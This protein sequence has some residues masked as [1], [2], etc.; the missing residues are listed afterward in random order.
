MLDWIGAGIFGILFLGTA[1]KFVTSVRLVQQ[2]R[3]EV[4]E[5]LGRY[6]KT[7]N[8]GFHVLVPFVDKVAFRHDLREE[9][10][11]VPP[12][13][14]F[15]SDNVRV[16]V[17]GVI[18]LQVVN[19]E[20]A[21][22][23]ITNYRWAAM[24][25]AQTTTRAVIG[26][27]ELDRTFEDRDAINARVVSV[28]N[29]AARGWG[30]EVKRYEVKN[31]VP[32]NTVKDAME[33]QMAAERDRRA[34]LARAEGEKMSRINNAD[35][36][37]QDLINR[38]EGEKQKRINEAEGRGEEI[39]AIAGATAESIAKIGHAMVQPG[40]T[41]AVRLRL[42]TKHIGNMKSLRGSTV[43]LPADLTRVDDLLEAVGLSPDAEHFQV[44]EADKVPPMQQP[45]PVRVQPRMPVGGSED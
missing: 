26:T 32:P 20:R 12:Q 23:G 38:S 43:V 5:R 35:G 28:L 7:L 45:E 18:Y 25:L 31:I 16:E 3:A 24:Q 15:T 29:E 10:V 2:R 6:S 44:S 39:L 1:F 17:D 22:Y 37:R 9:S 42:S 4:V 19:P 11:D 27:L 21:S 13:E 36:K 33:R 40:G 34:L 30:L 14:C 8:A 41:D